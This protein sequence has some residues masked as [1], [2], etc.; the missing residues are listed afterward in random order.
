MGPA[1]LAAAL[2]LPLLLAFGPGLAVPA[3]AQDMA[4][5]AAL[6]ERLQATLLRLSTDLDGVPGYLMRD[7][8]SGESL[9]RNADIVFP[10]ASVIKLPVLLE[11]YRQAEEGTLDLARP[12]P[13]DPKAR[14]EGGGVLEK[15]SAP[16]PDLSAAQLAVLMMDF[17]DNYA[18]NLL[19]DLVGP[20]RVGRRL[21]GWGFKETLLR[22]KMMDLD[23][24]RAGR[25]NVSTPREMAA[26]LERLGRGQILDADGTGRVIAIMKRN[27]RT[28]LKRALPAGIEAADKEGELDGVRCSVG[29]VFVPS[30]RAPASKAPAAGHPASV[31]PAAATRPFVLA[32]MTTYLKDDS[33]GDAYIT[34]VTR[35]AFDYFSALASSSEYGRRIEP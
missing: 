22:R 14:V 26:L 35:A 24:A 33:A 31:D 17:S 4:R 11:L 10:V 23:A 2:A 18:T 15:W 27:E 30:G 6:R 5:R 29:I 9:E 34:A 25:E 32:V 28:P 20:D 3:G 21:K 13:I 19:I 12:V 7:L 1:A 16:Y 8:A